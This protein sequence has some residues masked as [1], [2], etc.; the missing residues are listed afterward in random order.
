MTKKQCVFDLLIVILGAIPMHATAIVQGNIFQ[1]PDDTDPTQGNTI[2]NSPVNS[3]SP[4]SDLVNWT[5]SCSTCTGYGLSGSGAAKVINGSLGAMSSVTVTGSPTG[6][7][8]LGEANSY[9]QYFDMLTITGG[10]GSGV[11][12]LQYSL[13]GSSTSTGT[14]FN[15]SFS[16]L[17][18][19]G[20]F[21]GGAYFQINNGALTNGQEADFSGSGT[22]ADTV[23]FYLPFTYG[24]P[25]TMD[26]ILRSAANFY[27]DYDSTPY[28]ATWDFY[29]T[30]TVTSALVLSGTAND[31]GT[32]V[33]A[34]ITSDS[35]LQYGANGISSTPEPGTWLLVGSA[36]GTLILVAR[37]RDLVSTHLSIRGARL[38]ACRVDSHVDVLELS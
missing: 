2:F 25:F 24:T 23:T 28:T 10:S 13:D 18:I 21:G 33:A 34:Q 9:A 1:N 30:A 22:I 31:P 15:L 7:H 8:Y 3:G 27:A 16:Y 19:E 11:L 32:Q 17:A 38:Q 12:Q 14:G 5:F 20:A 26:P 36:M 4:V 35:G 29:N 37:R 6:A